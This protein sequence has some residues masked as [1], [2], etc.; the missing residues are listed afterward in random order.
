MGWFSLLMPFS[1]RFPDPGYC[2][3]SRKFRVFPRTT[4]K[5][6]VEFID[7]VLGYPLAI[8]IFV[9]PGQ[10]HQTIIFSSIW[11]SEIYPLHKL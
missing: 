6:S 10:T 4:E 11:K 3:F 7:D 8:R 2:I 9:E 1:R 5:Q